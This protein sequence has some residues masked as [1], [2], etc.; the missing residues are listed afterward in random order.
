MKKETESHEEQASASLSQAAEAM[1]RQEKDA[2]VAH[3]ES[4][5]RSLK[6]ASR[7]H[8]QNATPKQLG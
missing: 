8:N 2:A 5:K 6:R 3:I 7:L 4:A 1:R